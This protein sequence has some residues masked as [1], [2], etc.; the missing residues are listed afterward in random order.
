MC[1]GDGEGPSPAPPQGHLQVT[2][3][4]GEGSRTR[5]TWCS[6]SVASPDPEYFLQMNANVSCY[7]WRKHFP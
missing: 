7:C 1:D 2:R 6:G 3:F 4:C 5:R